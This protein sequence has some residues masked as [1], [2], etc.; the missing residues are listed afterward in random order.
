MKLITETLD[1]VKTVINEGVDG[2]PK[3]YCI[4]GVFMQ[5]DVANRNR[6]QYPRALLERESERYNRVYIKEKR[7]LG[8]LNHPDG[9][10]INLDRVSHIITELS[11]DGSNWYGKARILDTTCGR[12]VKILMD[13]GIKIGVST[14]GVGTLKTGQ[15]GFSTVNEDFHL[16]TVDIVADPSAPDA[17][18]RSIYENKEWLLT[19]SG[20]K[21]QD[22]EAA[23]K[24]LAEANMIDLEA[25]KLAVFQSFLNSLTASKK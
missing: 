18:V 11:Q 12:Q 8:E 1:D 17:F 19:E 20:W 16:A 4:E 21:E 23:K 10:T 24:S 15:D 25:R 3:T 22:F 6:R 5:A 2:K 9:P 7:A 14:R 13:E